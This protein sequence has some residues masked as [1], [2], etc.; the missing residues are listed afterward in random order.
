MSKETTFS[1]T[2]H[3]GNKKR[4]VNLGRIMNLELPVAVELGRI[5]MVV[6]DIIGLSPGFVVPM[7]KSA[8]EPVDLYLNEVKIAEGEIIAIAQNMG[9]RIT[10]LVGKSE[11]I[12]NLGGIER[13]KEN[14]HGFK[15]LETDG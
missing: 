2:L 4:S 12:S 1:D 13:I 5:R 10:A 8:G 9:I 11:R 7:N 3:C 15:Q 14:E 6:K